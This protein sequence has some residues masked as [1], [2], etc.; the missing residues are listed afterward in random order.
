MIALVS[1]LFS[2]ASDSTDKG[3]LLFEA[4]NYQEAVDAYTEYLDIKPRNIKTLYNRGRAF[5]EL[6]Q[7]DPALE[8]YEKVLKL[9][10]DHSRAHLSIGNIYFR[11][12]DYQQAY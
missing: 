7:F 1:I 6:G 12:E 9:D 4:G 10:P 2:C 3:D 11:N 5:E 8:D